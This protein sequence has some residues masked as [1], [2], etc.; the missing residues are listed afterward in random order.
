MGTCTKVGEALRRQVIYCTMPGPFNRYLT[1]R[2]LRR[3][4]LRT[5][6]LREP[7][8]QKLEQSFPSHLAMD[9][10]PLLNEGAENI[11]RGF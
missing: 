2:G 10:F 1:P 7:S 5:Q 8:Q 4:V 9:L 6:I 3:W 11:V